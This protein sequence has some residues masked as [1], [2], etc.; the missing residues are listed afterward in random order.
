MNEV[1]IEKTGDG[2]IPCAWLCR[3][4][5]RACPC[6]CR[7]RWPVCRSLPWRSWP[8]RG[9]HWARSRRCP[10]TRAGH[11]PYSR[12]L[13]AIAPVACCRRHRW[14]GGTSN[15]KNSTTN[16]WNL[17]SGTTS[18]LGRVLTSLFFANFKTLF[19][20]KTFSSN[21]LHVWIPVCFKIQW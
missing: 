3:P 8:R 12:A 2:V 6:S 4:A 7:C 14:T 19:R 16:T 15:H 10:L 17:C 18:F 11:S 20:W 13:P 9:C 5:P 21:Q 1:L